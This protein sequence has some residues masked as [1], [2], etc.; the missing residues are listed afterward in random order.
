MTKINPENYMKYVHT[1]S[2]KDEFKFNAKFET[3]QDLEE[4]GKENFDIDLRFV[5]MN[6]LKEMDEETIDT[7]L[8]FDNYFYVDD[9]P[10]LKAE[11]QGEDANKKI[12]NVSKINSK[13]FLSQKVEE[14][15]EIPKKETKK[16]EDSSD[17]EECIII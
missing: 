15:K 12:V 3:L 7:R 11:Y 6:F 13:D 5:F 9:I 14:K 16:D 17:E 10:Y 4:F 2:I 1:N 8:S